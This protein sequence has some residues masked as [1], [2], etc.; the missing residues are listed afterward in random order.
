MTK[1][2]I[3]VHCSDIVS[4]RRDWQ[5]DRSW[6]WCECDHAGVRWRDGARG[7]LEVT[8]V[9]GPD[10]VRVLGINNL[11][12]QAAVSANPYSTDGGRTFEQWRALHDLACDRVETNYLFHR[13]KR[14]C[15]A[16]VVRVG[17]SGD[18]TF[19]DYA[20]AKWPK[21]ADPPEDP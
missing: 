16:L 15:W 9:H 14:N 5:A 19:I 18:V 1:A 11:F 20:D 6:R 7:L 17:E 13:G 12:L 3:C 8:A 10:Y 2:V 21:D 4:P